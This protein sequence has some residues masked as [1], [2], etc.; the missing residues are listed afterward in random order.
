MLS[1]K[2]PD[3]FGLVDMFKW[4]WHSAKK[5]KPYLKIENYF[6]IRK[7]ILIPKEK[8]VNIV[9]IN[10]DELEYLRIKVL[11][12]DQEIMELEKSDLKKFYFT[13]TTHKISALRKEMWEVMQ[14]IHTL[15]KANPEGKKVLMSYKTFVKVV[16]TFNQ[17]AIKAL[18]DEGA[19]LKLGN[20][21]GY[22]YIYNKKK[23]DK[24]STINIDWKASNSFKQE[25]IDRG[26][27]PKDK[28][29]PDGKNWLQFYEEDDYVRLAW[30]KK[31][32]VCKVP[33]NSIYAFYPTKSVKGISKYL[34]HS[35]QGDPYLK[36]K[37]INMDNKKA[38]T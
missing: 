36:E 18:V 17:K 20:N 16:E 4:W 1:H 35:M 34:V 25:L 2:E 31:Y 12:I 7:K 9:S 22:I 23:S 29:N 24:F 26:D 13:E 21:L 27:T 28:Q 30:A 37:Y 10:K 38:V 11:E 32:G 8:D 6:M 14:R 33:N 5:E 15:E 3:V 19:S